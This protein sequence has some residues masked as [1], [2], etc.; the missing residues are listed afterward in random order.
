MPSLLAEL[1]SV[2][3]TCS[4][5]NAAGVLTCTNCGSAIEVAAWVHGRP[6]AP[7]P[8][9]EPAKPR[10]DGFALARAAEEK[11]KRLAAERAAAKA[12]A[13][14][15]AAAAAPAPVAAPAAPVVAPSPA[16]RSCGKC[17]SAI[18]GT[19]LFC[20]N[21][22]NRL[23]D[24]ATLAARRATGTGPIVGGAGWQPG[25]LKLVMLRGAGQEGAQFRLSQPEVPAGR[26]SL[27][28]FPNDDTLAAHAATFLFRNGRV[29]VRDERTK[30]GVYVRIRMPEVVR[31]GEVF[32]IGD[33][34]L[35]FS[36]RL[37]P[38]APDAAGT[39]PQGAPRPPQAAMIRLEVLLFG[40]A[41]GRGWLRAAPLR[42]GRAMGDLIFS[43]DPFISARHCE[44]DLDPEGAI[45]RDLGSSNGTFVRVPTGTERELFEGDYVR[46]GR[47]ILRLDRA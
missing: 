44:I 10:M 34:L 47:N 14:A 28:A 23:A 15:G 27:V 11:A 22:G 7:A 19:P 5:L 41:L 43:D 30:T 13:A 26:G 24:E 1:A 18:V 37:G 32:A 35:R 12:A 21:C 40:G 33:K 46:L 31:V 39:M 2:C 20:P 45:L 38:A 17:Q 16:P 4:R 6:P 9:P 42:I 25:S 36:G 3:Q 8:A 29:F